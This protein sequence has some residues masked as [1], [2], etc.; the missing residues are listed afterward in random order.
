MLHRCFALILGALAMPVAAPAQTAQGSDAS[1]ACFLV[2]LDAS[3]Q[4]ASQCGRRFSDTETG[5]YEAIR[6]RLEN[7]VIE[8]GTSRAPGRIAIMRGQVARGAPD[9]NDQSTQMA[10]RFV[11]EVINDRSFSARLEENL[12]QGPDPFEGGCL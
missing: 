10:N 9:C 11:D 1:V 6:R 5:R 3:L 7:Y 12:A 2:L 8:N 4:H